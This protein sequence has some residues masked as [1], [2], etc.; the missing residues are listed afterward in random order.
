MQ[1]SPS[2]PT[3]SPTLLPPSLREGCPRCHAGLGPQSPC[4]ESSQF[5]L[6]SLAP[7]S[8]LPR[9][10]LLSPPRLLRSLPAHPSSAAWARPAHADP[11]SLLQ[12]PPWLL[13]LPECSPSAGPS[14]MW[15]RPAAQPLSLC[16][17]SQNALPPFLCPRESL[18]LF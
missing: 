6:L 2:R 4:A 8:S 17:L 15:P 14:V 9:L 11:D 1:P 5:C 7:I 13:L 18:L 16:H 10:R 3:I 12:D